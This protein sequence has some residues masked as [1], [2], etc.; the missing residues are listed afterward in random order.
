TNNQT[1]FGV[2]VLK[3]TVEEIH[4]LY[5]AGDTTPS[6]ITRAALD[7]IELDNERLNA[8][9]T[10]NRD[11]ALN[12]AAAM[13][14]EIQS[15]IKD[16]PLAGIPVAL[17]DNLCTEGLRTTCGSHI[18]GNYVPQYTATVV[19]KLQAAGAIIVGKTNLDEF[20]MGS[21]TENSGFGPARNPH[22]PG[23]VP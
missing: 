13:D 16:K 18:L 22:N 2:I 12:A 10:V 21:S 7:T 1:P 6:E 5:A 4:K 20:A 19:Q 17:K 8:Y 14:G 11:C 23:Y 9:L 3:L 15:T